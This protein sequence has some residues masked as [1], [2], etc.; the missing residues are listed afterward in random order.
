MESF[1]F[2]LKAT[3]V[4]LFIMAPIVG[5]VTICIIIKRRQGIR[6]MKNYLTSFHFDFDTISESSYDVYFGKKHQKGDISMNEQ[7]LVISYLND[8][9]SED[10]CQKFSRSQGEI[11]FEFDGKTYIYSAHIHFENSMGEKVTLIVYNNFKLFGISAG[12]S[13]T[14]FTHSAVNCRNEQ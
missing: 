1:I 8:D 13:Y 6:K 7:E 4:V 9:G 2:V 10:L 11:E 3:L 14:A 12:L 5:V